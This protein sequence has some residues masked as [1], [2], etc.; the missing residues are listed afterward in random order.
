MAEILD[1]FRTNSAF[2][3]ASLTDALNRV[4]FKPSR[5]GEMG[6]FTGKGINTTTA[7]FEE[8]DGVLA[9]IPTK[10]RGEQ[11]SAARRGGRRARS[12]LVPHIPLADT[13]LADD[14][15]NVREF[16]SE[17]QLESVAAYVTERLEEIRQSHEVTLEWHR[18]GAIQGL[19]KD[20]DGSST[21]YNLFTEFGV[22][23]DTVNFQ[24][25]VATTD[26]RDKCLQVLRLVEAALGAA[27]Y[28][29]VHALCGAT[30]FTAFIGH[31]YVRDAYHRWRDSENLRNDP[32]RGFEFGGIIFEE[33]R[34]KI[35][36][37]D[38]VPLT[39]AQFFP[40]GV[41]RLFQTVHAPAN[42]VET[43]NT[44]GKP[45]YAKQ[46]RMK[47][48]KGIELDTQQNPL[49]ICTRPKTLVQGTN[50]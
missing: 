41:P 14:V 17:S 3:C 48:D 38:M 23:R 11:P 50:T 2:N 10:M 6:L 47:F 24:L 9:L 34:G 4:P 44:I 27:A 7:I 40:V 46:E 49:C 39:E 45:F 37:I 13:I 30:W 42:Y 12:F 26:V 18:I 25:G 21:I 31:E 20:A 33:Y 1:I 22:S 5:L 28:D 16:G 29:H 43:V 8:K 35:G 19:I 15:Q 32:R 36:N